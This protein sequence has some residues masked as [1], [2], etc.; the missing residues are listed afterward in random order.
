MKS[1]FDGLFDPTCVPVRIS[2]NKLDLV[3]NWTVA[4]LSSVGSTVVPVM[5]VDDGAMID[6]ATVDEDLLL[7]DGEIKQVGV[8]QELLLDNVVF[9]VVDILV[10]TKLVSVWLSGMS[11]IE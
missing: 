2:I 9:I 11:K 7:H 3:P 4:G 6:Q 1:Y 10:A 8:E 5:S